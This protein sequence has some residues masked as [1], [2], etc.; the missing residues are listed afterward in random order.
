[1]ARKIFIKGVSYSPEGKDPYFML[2]DEW[3]CIGNQGSTTEHFHGWVLTKR[4]PD[5]RLY[6][7]Y[8]FSAMVDGRSLSLKPGQ[9]IFVNTCQGKDCFLPAMEG[10]SGQFHLYYNKDKFIWDQPGDK[11]CLFS[12]RKEKAK[13]I[14]ELVD[15]KELQDTGK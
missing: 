13:E 15:M 14:Y 12:Y 11:V 3:V 10:A 5:G 6:N 8:Y 7:G 9:M 2:K 4:K 1:M